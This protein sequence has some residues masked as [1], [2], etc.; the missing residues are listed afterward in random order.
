MPADTLILLCALFFAGAALYSSVGHA[1]ASAYLA[2]MALLSVPAATMRPTALVLNVAVATI[3]T[4]RYARAGLFD[5]RTLWPFLIGSVP[6]AF[7]GG[8][9][10]L[11]DHFYRPLLGAV[12]WVAAVRLLMPGEIGTP[13]AVRRPPLPVALP[14]GAAIGLLAGLTGTG[15]GIFL[16]PLIIFTG[17]AGVREA[18]GI[19]A[20][21]ILCNSASGLLGNVAAVGRVPAEIPLFLACVVAGGFAGTTLG[22][23]RLATRNVLRALGLVLIVAGAKLIFD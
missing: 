1:G 2:A 19:A 6:F 20:A 7:L 5:W 22:I 17:W 9:I 18:S 13:S 14:A 10:Q 23:S 15:G 8:S 21:F 16:S 3:G 4:I 11:P 12:L